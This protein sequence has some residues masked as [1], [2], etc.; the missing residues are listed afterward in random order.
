MEAL[1]PELTE[2]EIKAYDDRAEELAK[3]KGVSKVHPV[4]Q[5]DPDT[6]ERKVCYLSEPNYLTKIRVMDKATTIGIY[7]AADELREACLLREAS[8]PITYGE[9]PECD[10]YK[11]GATD[12]ALTMVTR[13]QNQFKKK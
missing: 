5:I 1:K 12:Y 4:V 2:E 10:R 7:T 6:L 13:L 9:A 11:L 8:D 3:Q